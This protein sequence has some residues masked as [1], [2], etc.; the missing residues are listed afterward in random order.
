M[1]TV[2]EILERTFAVMLSVSACM[3]MFLFGV[4]FGNVFFG[5]VSMNALWWIFLGSA[6]LTWAMI[7]ALTEVR[8]RRLLILAEEQERED[9]ELYQHLIQNVR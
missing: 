4:F 9:D 7:Q 5:G 3:G 1:K 2:Y 6:A 8:Y